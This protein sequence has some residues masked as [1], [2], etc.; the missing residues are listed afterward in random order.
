MIKYLEITSPAN[1]PYAQA[2]VRKIHVTEGKEI[3]PGDILM[4]VESD[5]KE[6]NVPTEIKGR[7]VELIVAENEKISILTPLVLVETKMSKKQAAS[8]GKEKGW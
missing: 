6:Y 1:A 5:G 4:T 3:N 2:K 8:L 7:V